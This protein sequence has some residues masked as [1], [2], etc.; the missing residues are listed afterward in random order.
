MNNRDHWENLNFNE[1]NFQPYLTGPRGTAETEVII[2]GNGD[3]IVERPLRFN[4]SVYRFSI[5]AVPF[6]INPNTDEIF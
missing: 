4:Y 2:D 3:E 6:V 5:D 1:N